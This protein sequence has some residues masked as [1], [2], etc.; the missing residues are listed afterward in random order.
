[1][2][3]R[4]RSPSVRP[5]YGEKRVAEF[6]AAN[7]TKSGLEIEFARVDGD[8]SEHPPRYNPVSYTHLGCASGA[9]TVRIRGSEDFSVANFS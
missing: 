1:M 3:I 5:L 6:L 2:C 9:D 4:D 8:N 7:A